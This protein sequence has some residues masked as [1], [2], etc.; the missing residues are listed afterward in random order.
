[1]AENQ[2]E[3]LTIYDL[4]KGDPFSFYI[5]SYQRGFRW[6]TRQVTDLIND[7][8]EFTTKKEK[9]VDEFYCLQPIVVKPRENNWEVIDGQQR[10]T[11]IF[12]LLK[13]FNNRL[14]EDFR[15]DLYKI[16]YETREN[17]AK[18]LETISPE[19]SQTNVDYFHIHQAYSTIRDWFSQRQNIINDFEGSLLN[20]T[21]IIW[22]Q[23]NEDTDSID[24]FT[25]LNIGKIPLTNAE[26]IKALF[27][28]RDNFEGNDQTKQL[29]QLEIA[30]EWDRI[31]ANL[32]DEEFWGFISDGSDNFDN[33]IEF[34]FDLMSNKTNQ[35]KDFT[36]RYFSDLFDETQDVEAAWKIVK[37]YF[38]IFQE[39]FNDRDLY[40]L[41]GFLIIVGEKVEE[42]KADLNGKTKT[43]F[44]E[45]LKTKIKKY[46]NLQVSELDY[47]EKSDRKHIKNVLVLFN[48]ISIINNS[49][50]NYR[51]QFGRFKENKN[52]D[53]E[54]IH[55]VESNMPATDEHQKV[56]IKEF[57]EFTKDDDLKNRAKNWLETEKKSREES[58]DEVY[59]D[60]LKTYS[61]NG[62]AEE[63]NDISNL[64]LLDAGTN[65]GYGNAIFPIKR[66]KIIK[67]DQNGTFIPLCTKN[68]FLKYYT[69]S[70][71]QMTMW[72]RSDKESYLKAIIDTLKEFL[73][74]QN[75]NN[76]EEDGRTTD[77]L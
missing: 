30:G 9:K 52:W 24:I 7:I 5:P 54:H 62:E 35:D 17:S 38:L 23:V 8:Y 36:F 1:M 26:L 18:Y 60:I 13:Y 75:V 63:I 29:R 27:L 46:A 2:L 44:K 48:I 10:L 6:T 20:S 56:W 55:A 49:E 12:L 59:E 47:S 58:F 68:V 53:I 76:T 33:R 37:N 45:Y 4:I 77:I 25:R 70:V 19:E 74:E 50:S 11:T 31:E 16:E 3:L 41:I 69:E 15:K 72:G 61:E 73:P 14:A 34:I 21:K 22:Y 64:T 66:N 40:H 51:F 43:E 65:R 57:L 28:F 67:K 42:L 71:E 39:W 32:R